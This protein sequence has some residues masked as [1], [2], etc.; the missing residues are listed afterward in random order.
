[1]H[2]KKKNH[3]NQEKEVMHR[4][5]RNYVSQEKYLPITKRQTQENHEIRH[6][7]NYKK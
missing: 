1:M 6:Q 5:R 7:E 4:K 2:R 3:A